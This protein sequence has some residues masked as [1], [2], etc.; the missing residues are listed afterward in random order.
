MRLWLGRGS[1][2]SSIVSQLARLVLTAVVPLLVFTAVLVSLLAFK[3]REAVDRGLRGTARALKIAVDRELL[4]TV[5]T[6]EALGVGRSLD[7]GDL[8]R[9]YERAERVL[10]SQTKYGWLTISLSAPDGRQLLNLLRP[11]GAPLPRDP[12]PR[13]L[14]QAVQS[15]KPMI[16]DL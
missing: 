13:S 4:S 2:Q 7:T 15:G 12:D 8:Q 3:E 14:A 5:T 9:F 11:L 10:A 1:R 6:L 16:T